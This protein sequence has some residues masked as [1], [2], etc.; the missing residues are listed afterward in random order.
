ML[1]C[2]CGRLQAFLCK[3]RTAQHFACGKFEFIYASTAQVSLQIWASVHTQH[4]IAPPKSQFLQR[5]WKLYTLHCMSCHTFC[6]CSLPSSLTP[7]YTSVT[8]NCTWPHNCLLPIA[9]TH[10]CKQLRLLSHIC[11]QK[12]WSAMR[13]CMHH[14]C[15]G[16][17]TQS[18]RSSGVVSCSFS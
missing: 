18:G 6:S 13:L 12:P 4:S 1:M 2:A 7:A 15:V 9:L 8:S 14:S 5:L 16:R 10:Y 17:R 11:R 3:W